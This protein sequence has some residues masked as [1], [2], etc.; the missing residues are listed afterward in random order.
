MGIFKELKQIGYKQRSEFPIEAL[1]SMELTE[2]EKFLEIRMALKWFHSLGFHY[3]A[4]PYISNGVMKYLALVI[5][6]ES[7]TT[8]EDFTEHIECELFCL[9]EMVRRKRMTDYDIQM[10]KLIE[11]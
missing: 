7:R 8:K 10:R 2:T 9:K 11:E 1:D 5:E 4:I 3:S 6:G